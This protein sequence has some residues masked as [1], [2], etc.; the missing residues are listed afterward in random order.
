ME[1]F[2]KPEFKELLPLPTVDLHFIFDE[3]LYKK[4]HG[5]AMGLPLGPTLANIFLVYHK[6]I[7]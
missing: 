6:K 4:I 1:S 5:V 7:H 3:I 2:S